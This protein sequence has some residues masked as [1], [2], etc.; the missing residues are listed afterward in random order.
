VFQVLPEVIGTV[1]FFGLIAL[2]ELV[3]LAQM[4]GPGVPVCGVDE[5]L[6]TVAAHVGRCGMGCRSMEGGLNSG[7]GC[8]RPRVP[9][10]VQ[11]VLVSLGLVLVLEAIR[12]VLALVLLFHR[13]DPMR[14]IK[15]LVIGDGGPKLG[16]LLL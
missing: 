8:A 5:F 10:E 6:S 16:P 2:A 13:V 14:A 3:N 15:K 7:Q 12:T 4:L 11:R 1:E 9:S